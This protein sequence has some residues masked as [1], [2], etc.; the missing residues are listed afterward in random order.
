MPLIRS[1]AFHFLG[2]SSGIV[3]TSIL[4]E[5]RKLGLVTLVAPPSGSHVVLG[6][7][8]GALFGCAVVQVGVLQTLL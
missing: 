8:A 6:L 2:K 7:G 3:G 5:D 1:L 4:R